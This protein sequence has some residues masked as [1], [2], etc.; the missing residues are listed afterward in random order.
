MGRRQLALK[1]WVAEQITGSGLE[2]NTDF[3]LEMVAGDASF[4]RYFRVRAQNQSVIVMDAPPEHEDCGPFVAIAQQWLAAGVR[5]PKLLAQ[6]L[7]QGFLLLEDF[8]DQLLH[9]GLNKDSADPLYA[10][11]FTELLKIQQISAAG[12]PLYDEALL[13]REMHLFREWF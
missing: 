5:V 2:L 6:D 8:G 10:L 1:N 12:L 13:G 3:R 9:S 4:R 7:Q 11:A